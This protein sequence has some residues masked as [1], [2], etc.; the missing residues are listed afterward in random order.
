MAQ[1]DEIAHRYAGELG[2]AEALASYLRNF[3]YR[4]GPEEKRGLTEFRR[5]VEENRNLEPVVT[6]GGQA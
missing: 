1:I 5:L 3:R 2:S 6:G 4:L